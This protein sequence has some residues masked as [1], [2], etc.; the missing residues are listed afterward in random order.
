MSLRQRL[1]RYLHRVFSK[2]PAPFLALRFRYSGTMTWRIDESVLTTQVTGG[3]GTSL[4]IDLSQ[5]TLASLSAFIGTQTGYTVLQVPPAAYADLSA[6]VLLEGS[7]DQ[8]SANG[9]HLYGFTS[10]E[11]AYQ[12]AVSV[13]LIEANQQI[14]KALRQMTTKTGK[15]EWLDLIGSY[16]NVGRYVDEPDEAYGP[17]IIYEVLTPRNNNK[18]IETAITRAT[19]GL[20]SRVVDVVLPGNLFPTYGSGIL[21][22]GD[23]VYNTT[24]KPV[25]CLFDV[26][27]ALDLETTDNIA[28]YRYWVGLL[29]DK[30][31]SGG[32]H[33][34]Q[35]T[36]T[37]ALEDDS[38]D[39]QEDP[40]MCMEVFQHHL[41]NGRRTY[42]GDAQIAYYNGGV[43][44]H[45]GEC[46]YCY[47]DGFSHRIAVCCHL[48]FYATPDQ[49]S[50]V[51][52]QSQILRD[53]CRLGFGG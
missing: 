18:A 27:Y 34:R 26:E 37:G 52:R 4:R 21:H 31:R 23:Y 47:L 6:R 24:G 22:N 42:G 19:G 28:L 50:E 9:D 39:T 33:L 41:Y 15:G 43:A 51:H 7:K 38:L 49:I 45:E 20:P 40:F 35:I 10:L 36:L 12:D 48:G 14:D 44:T 3:A 32:T 46:E 17:R 2:D 8:F 1:V 11:W 13:E 25:R 29:I 16:Y 30:F 5:H 53:F